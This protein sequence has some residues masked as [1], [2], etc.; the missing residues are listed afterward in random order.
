MWLMKKW[1]GIYNFTVGTYKLM[2]QLKC[3]IP[4][5]LFNYKVAM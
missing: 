5:Q 2:W 1:H 4:Y 3:P